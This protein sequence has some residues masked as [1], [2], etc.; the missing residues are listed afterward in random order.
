MISKQTLKSQILQIQ[1]LLISLEK[2]VE[3]TNGALGWVWIAAD[4]AFA[5]F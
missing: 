4:H 1:L 3:K 2:F 5:L